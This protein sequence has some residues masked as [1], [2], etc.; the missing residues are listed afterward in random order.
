M[1]KTLFTL[2]LATISFFSF[3]QNVNI[4]D[5][6]FKIRL[7]KNTDINTD[8]DKG[9][10]S[11]QEAAA[12]TGM[13]HVDTAGILS[14]TGIEAFVN[15]TSFYCGSNEI[16]SLDVSKNTAL[17]TFVCSKNHLTSLDI[18]KNTALTTLYCYGNLL[19]DVDIS[20]NIVL[21]RIFCSDN[22]LGS[23]D[24]SKN[25]LLKY[26]TCSSTQLSSLDLIKNT[27]LIELVCDNNTLTS[28]DLSKNTALTTVKCHTNLLTKL[29]VSKN[30]KLKFLECYSNPG[31]TCIQALN[32]QV[33][34]NWKKDASAFYSADCA[35][36]TNVE[37][38]INTQ[39]RTIANIYNMQ[40]QEVGKYHSGLVI[41]R[42]TDGTSEKAIQ[43]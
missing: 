28:L 30:T 20:K 19:S 33:K 40:G 42:Y 2:I 26:L 17:T 27:N 3:G 37:D 22:N 12:Y 9:N 6:Q 16:T 36:S 5:T 11:I 24:V 41:Y 32:T 43:E 29:D 4:P 15:I 39:P 34:T 13:I 35:L 7:L 38:T 10:I 25:L 8:A 1:K 23:L 21:E 14:A 18:S 31:I